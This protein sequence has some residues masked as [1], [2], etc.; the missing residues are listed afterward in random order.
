ML[1]IQQVLCNI[2]KVCINGTTLVFNAL[3]TSERT[4]R[5]L[6][7]LSV[8]ACK[9][10]CFTDYRCFTSTHLSALSDRVWSAGRKR[11]VCLSKSAV[12]RESQ[13]CTTSYD[14]CRY[15]FARQ[16]A[17]ALCSGKVKVYADYYVNEL[18]PKLMDDCHHLLGQHFI[19][20]QDGAP[21]HA[22][23]ST[24][25]WPIAHCPSSTRTHG[26]QTARI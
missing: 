21:A 16:W 4:K 8:T 14:L 25:H 12:D 20:Q 1:Q 7:R 17:L 13:V 26:L 15:V 18:Q 3:I 22:A 5:L 19:F 2:T 6:R 23:K 24:Q 9:Q 10:V 11:D